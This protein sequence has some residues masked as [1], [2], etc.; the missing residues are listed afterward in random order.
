M[1]KYKLLLAMLAG[2]LA[3]AG[4]LVVLNPN[5]AAAG[6]SHEEIGNW[7]FKDG[8]WID[9]A[10]NGVPDFDQ[11]QNLWDNPPGSG[12]WTFCG[13]VAV[14]N[15]LWWFDSKF[16]PDPVTPSGNPPPSPHNDNYYLV[17]SYG[18][19][20]PALDDHDPQNVGG[21]GTPGLVDDL[22]CYFGTD[23]GIRGTEVHTMAYG[24]QQ[25]LYNDP[26]HPC[27]KPGR[28][29]GGSYYDDYHVQLVKMP[30]WEWVVEEVQRSED[31]ILLLGFWQHQTDHWARLG[32]H[33]VT[34]PGINAADLQIA[35]SDPFLDNA[36]AGRAGRVLSGT[37]AAHNPPHP[38]MTSIHNDA[39]NVSHDYYTVTLSAISPGGLWEIEGYEYDLNFES[40]NVPI[41]FI[42][43]TGSDTGDTI[44]VEVEYALAMSPFK[45]KPG[46]EW[47]DTYWLDEWITEWW[48]YKDDGDSCMPDFAWADEELWYDGPTALANSFWWFDSKA[49]TLIFGDLNVEP[50]PD[51]SDH[52]NLIMP[53]GPWDDH[54][55][56]NVTPTINSLA[57]WLN[58]GV[59]GTTRAN[60][61]NGIGMYLAESG[62]GDDWYTE[63]QESPDWEWI[64][65]EVET[66]EDVIMQLGFYEQIDGEWQRKGGHW[67]NAAGVNREGGFVGLS[68]PA[69]DYWHVDSFFDVTMG[70]VFPPEHIGKAFTETE[71]L[72]PQAISHEIYRVITS[73]DFADQLLLAGY[74]FTRTSVLTNFIG[75]NGGGADVISW[76]NPLTTVVEWAIGVSPHSDLV[77]TKTAAV[78]EVVAGDD[79]RYVLE[80]ANTGLAVAENV[81]ITDELDLERLT[82][83][84]YTSYPPIAA[85]QGVTHVWTLPKLS[86]GQR[87]VI[88]VTAKSLMTMTLYNEATITGTTSIGKPTPDGNTGNNASAICY[89]VDDLSL[90]YAPSVPRVGQTI[91]FTATAS[92][93]S[94][95]TYTWAAADGWSASG[96]A[97]SY[98]F[99]G[100]GNHTVWLTATNPCGAA[101][102]NTVVFVQ[103]YGVNLDPHS[104]AITENPDKTVTYTLTLENTGNVSD[105]Y[106]IASAVS[107]QSWA[108]TLTSA[109]GPVGAG[110]VASFDVT[111]EIPDT[112]TDG[113]QSIATIT[114]T[115]QNDSSKSDSSVLTTTATTQIIT[116]GVEIAPP[117]ATGNGDPGD[118]VTYTLRVTNTG[119]A[120]DTIG[121]GCTKPSSWTTTYSAS[122]F[123]LEAG[124]GTDVEVYVGIPAGASAGSAEVITITATSQADH[125]QSD[126][127]ALTTTVSWRFIYL[128]LVMRNYQ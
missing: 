42:P 9:Y 94:P 39:G 62:V 2:M 10:P 66:C 52:Y 18:G 88:T 77:L 57:G 25:Y 61:A 102:T 119:N 118:A 45:W 91:H 49:E 3:A 84:V 106:N 73:T 46:G 17:T 20:P 37:L 92:G 109:V 56:R 26:T 13:P 108:T 107:G 43:D 35:F 110:D 70:R 122:A 117:T 24:L 59:N 5:R 7:Y 21:M 47:V 50:P 22:A 87:G 115:S 120:D 86:Y 65:D 123:G 112:A 105:T 40:Q 76:T 125:T 69:L 83:V 27:Y 72:D 48:A 78:T 12:N 34:V 28:S 111:V 63:T 127:A 19:Y 74:P 1:K 96:A 93:S 81:T 4:L 16:E 126:A 99:T 38:G 60:M 36:G 98:A 90:Q 11:K 82:N 6:V 58:T 75:W 97:P 89:A 116:R 124:A 71:K 121:L 104:G 41:E 8:G 14:A 55:T 114:A 85:T 100:R 67:V 68:D 79:V 53:Y 29:N 23:A 103:E 113:Q 64:A 33:Y 44:Y 54:D 15:S 101:Y 80:Y 31:V 30:P 51:E 32:G 128:P 95:I